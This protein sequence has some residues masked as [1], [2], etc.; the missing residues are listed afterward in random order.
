MRR[1]VHRYRSRPIGLAAAVS[2]AA[3]VPGMAVAPSAAAAPAAISVEGG[4]VA[5]NTEFDTFSARYAR[6]AHTRS[7]P[8]TT[9]G[10]ATSQTVP[11][12]STVEVRLHR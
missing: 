11:A 2:L 6:S 9:A 5:P 3:A 12:Y 10:S 1:S 7:S 4:Y 8:P